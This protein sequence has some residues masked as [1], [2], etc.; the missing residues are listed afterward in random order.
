MHFVKTQIGWA[1][2]FSKQTSSF[3]ELEQVC[4]YDENVSGDT[5]LIRETK[6]TR[7]G[8][9]WERDDPTSWLAIPFFARF[10]RVILFLRKKVSP[11]FENSLTTCNYLDFPANSTK[12]YGNIGEHFSILVTNQQQSAKSGYFVYIC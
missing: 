10:G 7:W 6:H 9:G 3:V 12:I 11:F 4:C 2:Y 8:G 5:C 1:I